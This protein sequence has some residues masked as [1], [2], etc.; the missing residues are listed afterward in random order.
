M[1]DKL[2]KNPSQRDIQATEHREKLLTVGYELICKYGID[3][4]GVREISEAAGVTTGTFYHN[5]KNKQDLLWNYA[6]S[7]K[8]FG[9]GFDELSEGSAVSRIIAFFTGAVSDVLEKDGPELVMWILTQKETSSPLY[10]ATYRL[11]CEGIENKELTG[12]RPPEELTDFILDCYRGAA[13]AWFRSE[14]KKDI[15]QLIRE[16]VGYG[17]EHFLS[18]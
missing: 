5:F 11:V 10:D 17:L 16:H 12:E 4:V 7:R 6:G 15:R 1:S 8:E 14:G 3:G 13:F 2:I 18:K 9:R